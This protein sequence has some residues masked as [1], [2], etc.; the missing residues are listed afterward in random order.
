MLAA[1]GRARLE[2]DTLVVF[3]SDNG[4]ERYSYNWPFSGGK[5]DLLEGGT[6]VPA[7]ARWPGVIAPGGSTDRPVI[8]MDWTAT[9]LA[10]AGVAPDARYPLDGESLMP[11]LRGERDAPDRALFWRIR[12]QGAARM[13]RWKYLREGQVERLFDLGVDDGEKA[14]LT[15][16]RPDLLADLRRRYDAWAADMLPLS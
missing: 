6:R 1:L 9:I 8:T 16:K 10:A 3:M 13:G 12:R 7:I 15:A 14:D 11:T 4:G 2:R 5:L